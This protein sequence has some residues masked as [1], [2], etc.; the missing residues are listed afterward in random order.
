MRCC[1][2]PCGFRLGVAKM[3]HLVW[4]RDDRIG[5]FFYFRKNHKISETITLMRMQVAR[6][7]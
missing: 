1:N 7:K 3:Q 2:S 6:G 4:T 5:G